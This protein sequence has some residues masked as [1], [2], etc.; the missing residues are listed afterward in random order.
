MTITTGFAVPHIP[1]T[2]P[3]WQAL[4][5]YLKHPVVFATTETA[6]ADPPRITPLGSNGEAAPKSTT[7]P[8]PL[9]VLFHWTVVPTL[10]QNR[11]LPFALGMLG[12]ADAE[13]SVRFTFTLHGLEADPHVLAA[14][15]IWAAFGSAHTS[16]SSFD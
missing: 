3:E 9:S 8:S 7:N 6:C 10:T 13:L 5:E 2:S 4:A 14:V 12:V 11:E 15:H 1:Y 16:L